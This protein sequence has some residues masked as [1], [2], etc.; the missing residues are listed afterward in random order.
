LAKQPAYEGRES[1]RPAEEAA[2]LL[3]AQPKIRSR[4][5]A[6]T[7]T[8]LAGGGAQYWMVI[9]ADGETHV[10]LGSDATR[11]TGGAP[12]HVDLHYY[13]SGGFYVY[14]TYFQ[15]WPIEVDG[16]PATLVWRGD[17]LSSASLAS[18]RGIERSAAGGALMRQIEKSS[19]FFQ[20]D[21]SAER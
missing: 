6:L 3:D 10:M 12:Q 8:V 18:L 19:S 13:G 1:V 16:A 14:L 7:G 11:A 20:K 15:L 21:A 17:L 4:F 9:D 2:L 5:S